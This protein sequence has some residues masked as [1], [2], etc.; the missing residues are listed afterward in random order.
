[1]SLKNYLT[2]DATL[3][4]G[5]SPDLA[6]SLLTLARSLLTLARSLSR[7]RR[8]GCLAASVL[9]P[10]HTGDAWNYMEEEDACHMEEGEA[11]GA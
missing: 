6:R 9:D 11:A 3:S 10:T 5:H 2:G 8:C 1:L 4:L 7:T